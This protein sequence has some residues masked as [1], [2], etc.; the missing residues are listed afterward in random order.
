VN[1]TKVQAGE[2]GFNIHALRSFRG[3]PFTLIYEKLLQRGAP[4]MQLEGLL[5]AEPGT[6]LTVQ[7]EIGTVIYRWAPAKRADQL[8]DGEG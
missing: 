8:A 5:V 7:V 4:V 3:H 2:V 1:I 6:A